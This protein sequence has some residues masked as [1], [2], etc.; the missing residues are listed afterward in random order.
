MNYVIK[1]KNNKYYLLYGGYISLND[2]KKLKGPINLYLPHSLRYDSELETVLKEMKKDYRVYNVKAL[3]TDKE[4]DIKEAIR[5]LIMNNVNS[6]EEFIEK[7][8]FHYAPSVFYE[9]DQYVPEIVS[10]SSYI[11]GRT[12]VFQY[13]YSG[14]MTYLDINSAY[15]YILSSKLPDVKTATKI[16]NPSFSLLEDLLNDNEK[17]FIAN[18]QATVKDD[19]YI[20][21]LP[22]R[23]EK[24]F[25]LKTL[26]LSDLDDAKDKNEHRIIYPVGNIYGYYHKQDVLN[27]ALSGNEIV[28]VKELYVFDL[29]EF[30]FINSFANNLYTLRKNAENP[31]LKNLFKL[32]LVILYGKIATRKRKGSLGNPIIGGYVTACVRHMLYSKM[33]EFEKEDILYCDT[34]GFLVKG[35]VDISD[36]SLGSW[37]VR[38]Y[39]VDFTA[40]GVKKYKAITEDGRLEYSMSGFSNPEE[41]EIIPINTNKHVYL[42]S[43]E[44]ENLSVITLP[45]RVNGKPML[46]FNIL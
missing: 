22:V 38:N 34:D 29:K 17:H 14:D 10:N 15:A 41:V 25:L 3:Y 27:L 35:K 30:K 31:A 13:Q 12:E 21:P 37:N 2:L 28:K 45:N 6:V 23:V 9:P 5:Y 43:C 46:A 36:K 32:A 26:G 19:T 16:D 18:I 44:K 7:H 39:Y 11:G 8:L 20:P 4:D 1:L 40:Y 24:S 42:L 33:L